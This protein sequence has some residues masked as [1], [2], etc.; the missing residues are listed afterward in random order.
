MNKAVRNILSV[1]TS[2]VLLNTLTLAQAGG[3]TD[4]DQNSQQ[5][6]SRLAKAAFWRHKDNG[7][8]T[9]QLQAPQASKQA[10]VK[11]AQIKPVSAKMSAD[12]KDQK[13][14][15][16]A[17]KVSQPSSKKAPAANKTKP[18]PKAQDRTTA[19]LKQ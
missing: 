19:S 10:P 18:Q 9:K 8:N 7:K 14:E 15:Q 12:K 6:H 16:H 5:H 4:K 11:T 17:S 1:M 13:P 3:N 2:L